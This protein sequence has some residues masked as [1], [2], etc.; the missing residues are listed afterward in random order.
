LL[1]FEE[2]SGCIRYLHSFGTLVA[3]II[4]FSDIF[5]TSKYLADLQCVANLW[6][7]FS[8]IILSTW[9]WGLNVYDISNLFIGILCGTNLP[10]M[11]KSVLIANAISVRAVNNSRVRVLRY[12]TDKKIHLSYFSHRSQ[13]DVRTHDVRWGGDIDI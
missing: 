8:F 6:L 13:I 7:N 1:S 5:V 3:C 9:I 10:L 2:T 11:T 12:L 4:W